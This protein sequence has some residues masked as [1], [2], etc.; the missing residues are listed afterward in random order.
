MESISQK[1]LKEYRYL[2]PITKKFIY[3]N[4]AGVA[5]IS[6][7]VADAMMR[8]S[9]ESLHEGY[10]AGPR[11]VKQYEK[12]RS[13]SAKLIGAQPDEVAFVKNT[14]HGL[15]LV[16]KG[17]NFIEGDE[18]IISELEFPS[19]VYPWLSLEKRGV[20]VKKIPRKGATLDLDQLPEMIT[21]RTRLLS[22]SSV[23]FN[24]GYR[25]PLADVGKLCRERGVLFCVDA[26][27]SLGAFPLDVVRDQVDFLAADAHKWLLGPE[28][29][30]IFYVRHDLIEQMDP[31]LL[32][33]N[34]V[35][36]ALDFDHI[37]FKLKSSARRFEEGSHNGVSIYALGAAIDLILEIGIDRIAE[38][39]LSL[40]DLLTQGLQELALTIH[41]SLEKKYRSGIVLFSLSGAP[42]NHAME[43]LVD[44]L[45]AKGIYACIRG[46]NLRLSPHFYNSETE[47]E[48]V[49]K[50]IKSFLD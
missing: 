27:Q 5:P 7:R 26:I 21:N 9:Q 28:G 43:E 20:K 17:L 16:A 4:H 47:V 35:Q 23:Q 44:H 18:I 14:S 8:F 30:G 45:F 49:L 48:D 2:F 31:V 37:D 41:H 40:T 12:V 50:E 25:L 24:T 6:M 10:T 34:S 33:W 13:L 36:G 15:S 29:I 1:E 32:G 38:R 11:W 3:F 42:Q 19:N 46:G 22:L 39:I